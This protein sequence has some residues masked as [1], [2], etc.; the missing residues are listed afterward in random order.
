MQTFGFIPWILQYTFPS[1]AR[2]KNG[3]YCSFLPSG[4]TQ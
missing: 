3:Q 4:E 1:P 2:K